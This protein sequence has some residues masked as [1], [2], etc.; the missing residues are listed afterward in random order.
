MTVAD[1]RG[2]MIQTLNQHISQ[3]NQTTIDTAQFA[4][5]WAAAYADGIE[6]IHNGITS[7]TTVDALN[8][9]A[10]QLLLKKYGIAEKITP[11]ARE[12]ISF[13]WHKLEPWPDAVSGIELLKKI[14]W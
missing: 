7:F 2:S 9:A 5:D 3:L 1:W 14:I 12:E 4:D 13:A 10:L 6:R 8:E 11:K